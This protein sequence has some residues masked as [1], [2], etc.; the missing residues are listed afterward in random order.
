MIVHTLFIIF[1]IRIY[2]PDI[3]LIINLTILSTHIIYIVLHII[4]VLGVFFFYLFKYSV[5]VQDAS[6]SDFHT[7]NIIYC[8]WSM[9]LIYDFGRLLLLY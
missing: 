7:V 4:D 5:H 1:I 3:V 6:R 9:F 8:F 2:L